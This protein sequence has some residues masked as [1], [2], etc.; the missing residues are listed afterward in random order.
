MQLTKITFMHGLYSDS[1]RPKHSSVTSST[2]SHT[3]DHSYLPHESIQNILSQ[4]RIISPPA[5]QS[6]DTIHQMTSTPKYGNTD[7]HSVNCGKTPAKLQ[8]QIL[9]DTNSTI[10]L[11]EK[12]LAPSNFR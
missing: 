2:F 9:S 7:A 5:L 6:C 8:N 11:R 3:T 4:K 10:L 12:L 1:T